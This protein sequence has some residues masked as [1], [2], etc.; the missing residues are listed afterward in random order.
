MPEYFGRT[1]GYYLKEGTTDRDWDK[2]YTCAKEGD[3]F[4]IE[5]IWVQN[6]D[7]WDEY[8]RRNLRMSGRQEG[9]RLGKADAEADEAI[10]DRNEIKALA[11]KTFENYWKIEEQSYNSMYG[12]W[13]IESINPDLNEMQR[14]FKTGFVEAYIKSAEK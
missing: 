5:L 7:A 12:A 9:L 11:V 2:I 8:S 6:F 3:L 1:M 10:E 4:A 14:V 13:P